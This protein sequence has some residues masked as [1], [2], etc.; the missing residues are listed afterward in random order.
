MSYI[1]SNDKNGISAKRKVRYIVQRQNWFFAKIKVKEFRVLM[2]KE[3]HS[4]IS[5]RNVIKK[6]SE[7]FL[8]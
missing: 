2:V 7:R 6:G 1:H 4:R 8:F 3:C 5:Y